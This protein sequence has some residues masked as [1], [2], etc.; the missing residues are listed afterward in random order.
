MHLGAA[1]CVCGP[2]AGAPS[3]WGPRQRS[4][5]S[6]LWP[7][8]PPSCRPQS[9]RGQGSP[10]AAR[11]QGPGPVAGRAGGLAVHGKGLSSPF[12]SSLWKSSLTLNPFSFGP[13]Y[14][15]LMKQ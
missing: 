8:A 12:S 1:P 14:M 4:Q 13:E 2:G 7:G 3:L 6:W 5:S 9:S 10:W 11:G 15:C